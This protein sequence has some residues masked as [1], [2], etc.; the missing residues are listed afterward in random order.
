MI[1]IARVRRGKEKTRGI[2]GEEVEEKELE[3]GCGRTR[4]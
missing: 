3:L 4:S 2:W 1:D